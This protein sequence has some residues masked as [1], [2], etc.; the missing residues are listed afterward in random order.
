MRLLPLAAVLLL[1]PP[2][3]RAEDA[4]APAAQEA[5]PE[6]K[7]RAAPVFAQLDKELLQDRDPYAAKAFLDR[8]DV[9]ELLRRADPAAFDR[10]FEA[11]SQLADLHRMMGDH[12]NPT[13]LREALSKRDSYPLLDKPAELLAWRKKYADY[14]KED[15]LRA[16]LLEW[17]TLAPEVRT[18]L[19]TAGKKPGDWTNT[20]F[21]E[22]SEALEAA[23]T[24]AV[25]RMKAAVARTPAEAQALRDQAGKIWQ[26]LDKDVRAALLQ[27]FE[28]TDAAAA[29]LGD[30]EARLAKNP[31][32]ALAAKLAEARKTGDVDGMLGKLGSLFD[33]MGVRNEGV[34]RAGPGRADQRLDDTSRAALSEMLKTGV[35]REMAGTTVGDRL[36]KMYQKEPFNLVVRSMPPGIMGMYHPDTNILSVSEEL[37]TRMAREQGK[38]AQD[39]M[40]GELFDKA[41]KSTLSTIVH[42]AVHQEQNVWRRDHKVPYWDVVEHEMEAKQLEA[43][44]VLQKSAQD[45]KGYG[46]FMAENQRSSTFVREG[47][48]LADKMWKS[49]KTFRMSIQADYY[50]AEVSIEANAA[51][52]YDN[53]TLKDMQA[54]V[55]AELARRAA[56]PSAQRAALEAAGRAR[57]DGRH[58]MDTWTAALS[59]LKEETLRGMEA[60][61]TQALSTRTAARADVPRVYAAYRARDAETQSLTDGVLAALSSPQPDGK[62]AGAPGTKAGFVPPPVISSGG[63]GGSPPRRKK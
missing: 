21:S 10:L 50:P 39:L 4:P 36:L 47:A 59:G 51:R 12:I 15:N 2:W 27:H 25:D 7:A 34:E 26:Y 42:E 11:A 19:S 13:S 16:A 14:Q 3:A 46:R 6:L 57:L 37:L 1:A 28:K 60:S 53:G 58:T 17:G 43:A 55:R 38:T 40:K 45:P 35:L 44:F 22:R 62:W 5:S 52:A 48:A 8:G 9:H 54:A 31:D 23:L 20:S 49:P 18:A 61:Q 41:L 63:G 33:G 24:P 30:A 56:L 32:P 29:A